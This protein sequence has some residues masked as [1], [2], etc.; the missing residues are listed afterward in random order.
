MSHAKGEAWR[1]SR[2]RGQLPANWTDIR[3]AVKARAG[4][5]CEKRLPSGA[6]CPRRGT[7]ADH[8]GDRDNHSMSNLEWACSFHHLAKSSIEGQVEKAKRAAKWKREP[9]GHPG[10]KVQRPSPSAEGAAAKA[11]RAAQWRRPPEGHPGSITKEE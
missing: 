9:E 10:T 6:R 5:R 2:R 8:V 1:G 4:G 11:D 3:K 7:D